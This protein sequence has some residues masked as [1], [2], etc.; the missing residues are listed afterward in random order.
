MSIVAQIAKATTGDDKASRSPQRSDYL[1]R[2][3]R[4]ANPSALVEPDTETEQPTPIAPL[5][6]QERRVL[7]LMAEG[8]SNR[9][10]ARKLFIA[11][12]TVKFHLR[13][14]LAKTA[15]RNRTHA[16]AIALRRGLIG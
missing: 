16:V 11:E 14:V 10:I 1:N 5:T 8:L 9:E 6:R 3:L 13:N 4:T 12:P 7:A 2:L 15:S